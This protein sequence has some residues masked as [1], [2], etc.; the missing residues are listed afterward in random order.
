M[1]F[2]INACWCLAAQVAAPSSM[3]L[4]LLRWHACMHTAARCAVTDC[5]PTCKFVELQDEFSMSGLGCVLHLSPIKRLNQLRGS[6]KE[7]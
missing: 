5:I 1:D 7:H 2:I 6:G 4:H 3:N